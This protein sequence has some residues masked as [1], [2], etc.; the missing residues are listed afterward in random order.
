MAPEPGVG[1]IRITIP[2]QQSK[3]HCYDHMGGSHRVMILL[4]ISVTS[5]PLVATCS[6]Y[7]HRLPL[8][9]PLPRPLDGRAADFL[10]AVVEVEPPAVCHLIGKRGRKWCQVSSISPPSFQLII[11]YS[12]FAKVQ[13][14]RRRKFAG[15][16]H[17]SSIIFLN[18]QCVVCHGQN[19][20]E[21]T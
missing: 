12:K 20:R 7:Y 9:A 19:K 8:C 3:R 16:G 13:I 10:G 21:E 18:I 1:G 15:A 6:D 4:V 14:D 5:C 17:K 2:S 11:T